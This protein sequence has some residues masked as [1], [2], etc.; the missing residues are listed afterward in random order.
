MDSLIS[1]TVKQREPSENNAKT[2]N[3]GYIQYLLLYQVHF[4]MR[5][6]VPHH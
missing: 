1:K 4:I 2:S 5:F 6:D 3:E